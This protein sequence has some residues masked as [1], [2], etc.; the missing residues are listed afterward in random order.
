MIT[1][2]NMSAAE[3]TDARLVAS[4]LSGD[5]E[6]FGCIVGRYQSLVCSLAYSA[7]GSLGTSEDLAQETFITAWKHLRLLREPDKLR[8]WLCG[9]ARNR[10]NN[11]LRRQRREPVSSAESLDRVAEA[12]APEPLPPERIIGQEQAALVWG[13]LERIPDLYREPLVL[14]YRE[15]RSVQQTAALLDLTEENV[16]QRLSRGRK[17][18][19]A[20]MTAC[21][22]EVLQQSAPGRAFTLG[23]LA[24]LPVF[25][26]SASAATVGAAAAKGS[27]AANSAWFVSL[28]NILLGP[29]IGLFGAYVGV[30]ASLNATR[31]PRERQYVMHQVKIIVIGTFAFNLL[32]G[33]YIFLA[34]KYWASHP[35]LF[36]A[37]GVGMTV[38]FTIFIVVFAARF[39]RQIRRLREEEKTLHPEFFAPAELRPNAAFKEYRSSFTFFGLPL[40]HIRHGAPDGERVRPAIGWIAIGDRAYGILFAAGGFACGGI[41]MGGVAVGGIA[42]GGVTLGLLS[43]G[44]LALGG[45][46]IGG[47]AVGIMA[48]GGFATAWWAAEGGMAVARDFAIG[49]AAVAAHANDAVAREFFS[50]YPWLDIS[51]PAERNW[52][53]IAYLAPGAPVLMAYHRRPPQ[54]AASEITQHGEVKSRIL[55]FYRARHYRLIPPGRGDLPRPRQTIRHR[56]RPFHRRLVRRFHPQRHVHAP[57]HQPSTARRHALV[58]NSFLLGRRTPRLS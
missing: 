56:S 7:T 57:R 42:L 38:C 27:A 9:I 1:R 49:G 23:V 22:E 48:V 8:S 47:A 21:V 26:T 29:L 17:L 16:K 25:A 45:L 10:I 28:F 3:Q 20:E 30:R 39:N 24:A 50:N 51:K 4:T 35:F 18:L 2:T 15:G 44:G 31:T 33:A 19:S 13:A 41:S 37:L 52:F 46:A 5:R 11:F 12:P 58:P 14:F 40:V 32:M 55:R 54:K 43:L 6:A 36:A 34:L 53:V